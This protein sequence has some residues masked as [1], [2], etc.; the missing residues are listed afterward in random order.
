M[1]ST[2]EQPD[3]ALSAE[4][5]VADARD[6]VLSGRGP[7]ASTDEVFN[8]GRGKLVQA[9]TPVVQ[10]LAE[11]ARDAAH[12]REDAAFVDGGLLSIFGLPGRAGWLW[13]GAGWNPSDTPERRERPWVLLGGVGTAGAFLALL[14]CHRW[15][16][17]RGTRP[18]GCA[19][20][21]LDSLRASPRLGGRRSG[22]VVAPTT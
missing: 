20:G 11:T 3:T 7:G 16:V 19:I 21:I 2:N 18:P 14:A 22:T 1:S 15:S 17:R 12:A 13:E 9:G 4:Q 10:R 5:T 6:A 8:H